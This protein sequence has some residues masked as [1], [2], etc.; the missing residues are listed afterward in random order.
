MSNSMSRW[1][2]FFAVALAAW[3]PWL[4]G[5]AS[6]GDDDAS[7]VASQIREAVIH[8]DKSQFKQ[9]FSDASDVSEDDFAY[10][11]GEAQPSELRRFLSK[12]S[13]RSRAFSGMDDSGRKIVTVVYFDAN[14]VKEP[15][16]LEWKKI[17]DGWLKKFAA[18]DVVLIGDKWYFDGTPFFFFR[19]APWAGDY[20]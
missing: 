9:F 11:F 5:C 4:T 20:G 15:T 2:L 6:T 19:H 1:L 8:A 12:K 16:A 3:F 18:I 10:Y 13:I 17:G 14:L 7:A